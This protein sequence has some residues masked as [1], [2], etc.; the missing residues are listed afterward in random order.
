MSLNGKRFRRRKQYTARKLHPAAIVGIVLA[1]AIVLTVVIGNLL[2][3][4][5]DDE[6]FQKLTSGKETNVQT[7]APVPKNVPNVNAYAFRLGD[8][9]QDVIGKNAVSVNINDASGRVLYASEV[10]AYYGIETDE[11]VPLLET[12]GELFTVVPYISG[13]YH[14]QA[15]THESE[16]VRYAATNAEIAVIREFLLAG[17]SE[18][19]IRDLPL[20]LE[21]IEFTVTYIQS[22]KNAL[23]SAPVGVAVPLAVAQSENGW[24]ILSELEKICD[25]C[26]LD[27]TDVEI[28]AERDASESAPETVPDEAETLEPSEEEETENTLPN[29]AAVLADCNYYL[30]QYGMRLLVQD[31]QE[32]LIAALETRLYSNFQ[33]VHFVAI[34]APTE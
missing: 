14:S 34:E 18:V 17:G 27:L 10:A 2:K 22:L 5:L 24:W 13:V 32:T 8:D 26:A 28:A 25:F 4:W 21:R 3:L 15:V 1:A 29:A 23:G 11:K 16:T 19:L 31:T 6:T 20:S 30:A 9:V 33:I 7:E 12:V